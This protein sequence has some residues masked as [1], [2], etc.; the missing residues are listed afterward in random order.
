MKEKLH[1]LLAA[2]TGKVI[3]YL[4]DLITGMVLLLIAWLASWFTKRVIVQLS[5]I[6]KF[7]RFLIRT[8]W[9][10]AFSMADVRY[11]FYNFLGNIGYW[12]VFL[13]FLR[14]I[15]TIWRL[16]FLSNLLSEII[17]FFPRILFSLMIFGI[18]WFI[19]RWAADGLFRM[20]DI[21]RMPRATL[22]SSLVRMMLILAFT[23]MSIAE[24]D[25]SRNIVVIGFAILFGTAALS[26]IILLH[27]AEKTGSRAVQP[28]KDNEAEDR[29]TFGDKEPSQ[30]SSSNSSRASES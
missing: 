6:F 3:E 21:E 2:L 26:L 18:G 13:I 23:S 10:K 20:L 24:L 12:V 15:L 22:F 19:A 8:R 30:D 27:A 16:H 17:S 11:G 25:I 28:L 14:E 5:V 4:P 29:N 1:S 7:E 9:R